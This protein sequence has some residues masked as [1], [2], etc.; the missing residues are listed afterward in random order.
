M[1]PSPRLALAP[2]LLRALLLLLAPQA[3]EASLPCEP[4]C[5]SPCSDLN[6][7]VTGECGGCA[8]DEFR[9]APGKPGYPSSRRFDEPSGGVDDEIIITV[10]DEDAEGT[11]I[12]RRLD[13]V[14]LLRM[15]AREL[16]AALAKPTIVSNMTAAWP[17]VSWL[18]HFEFDA[19]HPDFPADRARRGAQ[20]AMVRIF[21]QLYGVPE[22]FRHRT[23]KLRLSYSTSTGMGVSFCNHGFSWLALLMGA[24]HWFFAPHT[25]PAPPNPDCPPAS[26]VVAPPFGATYQCSQR[27]GELIVVPTAMWHATCNTGTTFAFGGEDMCDLAPCAPSSPSYHCV[28][29]ERTVE[30]HEWLGRGADGSEPL[31]EATPTVSVGVGKRLEQAQLTVRSVDP[32]VWDAVSLEPPPHDRDEL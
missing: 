30:C 4:W 29:V 31:R 13:R 14:D 17:D 1:R 5:V 12:C 27:A 26:G 3:P 8:G 21:H 22:V 6:G 20:E 15:D 9:C 10:P 23:S 11:S 25:V 28:D 32:A 18:Q 7:D 24:K 16:A 19:S 2:I